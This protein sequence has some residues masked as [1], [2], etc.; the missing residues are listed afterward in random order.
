MR[1]K[2]ISQNIVMQ[3]REEGRSKDNVGVFEIDM[4]EWKVPWVNNFIVECSGFS[5]DQIQHMSFIDLVPEQFHWMVHE[6]M[7]ESES[8]SGPT[9]KNF[10]MVWPMKT[11]DGKITWWSVSQKSAEFPVVWVYGE[12]IQTTHFP[13]MQFMF[14]RAFMRAANGHSCLR[15]E[16]S[17]LKDWTS[18]QISRLDQK[19]E[20]LKTSLSAMEAKMNDVLEA[21]KETA[22][23]VKTTH[24]MVKELQKS[25][26]DFETKYGIEILKLIG[27]DSVHDKRI[28]AFE[29]HVKMVTNL[30]VKSIEVQAKTSSDEIV[31]QAKESSKGLSVKVI[32]PVSVIAVIATLLQV[33]FEKL[34]P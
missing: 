7:L 33:L 19:D 11:A 1:K 10:P 26:A 15:K 31:E 2:L 25:F 6:F 34:V 23:A 17:E 9:E 16:I 8:A 3:K 18:A 24:C 27:T 29:Q 32:V 13:S 21:S 5:L 4:S 22:D 12:H 20:Q 30:A 28:D 14:M